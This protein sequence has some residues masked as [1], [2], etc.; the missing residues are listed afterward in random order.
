MKKVITLIPIITIIEEDTI[1]KKIKTLG[2]R[3]DLLD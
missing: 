2:Q 1:I 3:Y